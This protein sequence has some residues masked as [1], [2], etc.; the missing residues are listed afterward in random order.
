MPHLIIIAGPNGA[1][2]STT[3]PALLKDALSIEN[4]VNADVIAQGLCAYQPEKAAIEAGRVMLKRIHQLA[5]EQANFAFET[6]LASR[7]F[8]QWIPQLKA[9]G[10]QFY[11]M[12]LWL[13]DAELALFRVKERIKIGG[14]SVPEETIRRR[15]KAGLRNFFNLY[16]SIADVW[17]MYNNSD[18][19]PS[20]IAAKTSQDTVAIEQPTIWQHLTETYHER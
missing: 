20:L 19:R 3:A 9:K 8:A 16:M 14:H 18:Q 11:L 5:D 4:F 7:T 17:R 13:Q 10:Y 1:G 2:K 6:T 12:F 15:Y